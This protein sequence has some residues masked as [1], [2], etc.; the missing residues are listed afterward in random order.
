M[1][2]TC[3][4]LDEKNSHKSNQC[5]FIRSLPNR[6]SKIYAFSVEP[7]EEIF[8]VLSRD[9]LRWKTTSTMMT[10]TTWRRRQRRWC[11]VTRKFRENTWASFSHSP[12]SY[13]HV[14]TMSTQK[15]AFYLILSPSSSSSSLMSSPL[16]SLLRNLRSQEKL[17]FVL[18]P[19]WQLFCIWLW[20]KP[21]LI[22][23]AAVLMRYFFLDRDCC[24]FIEII[25][26]MMFSNQSLA[27]KTI[28][29]ITT[30]TQFASL[31]DT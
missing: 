11:D 14:D 25:Q 7:M 21:T 22:L 8:A 9:S 28:Q 16:A 2:S 23:S 15:N 1:A 17:C 5:G 10:T 18:L 12:V 29:L 6:I 27:W 3:R 4:H 13:F 31:F 20:L 19:R 26:V 24:T 30:T